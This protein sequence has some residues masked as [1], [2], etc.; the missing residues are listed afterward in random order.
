MFMIILLSMV[1]SEL[2]VLTGVLCVRTGDTGDELLTECAGGIVGIVGTCG[3]VEL[4][5]RL[6]CLLKS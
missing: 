4:E 3:Y 5:Y 1:G 2:C 6:S